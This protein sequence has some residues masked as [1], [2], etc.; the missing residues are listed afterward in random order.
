VGMWVW[1]VCCAGCDVGRSVCGGGGG[2]V[3]ACEC[4]WVMCNLIRVGQNAV[5]THCI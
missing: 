3:G 2:W 4:V 1:G 5:Y